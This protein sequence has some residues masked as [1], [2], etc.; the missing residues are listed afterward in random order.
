MRSRR[1]RRGEPLLTVPAP[2]PPYNASCPS[3]RDS[4]AVAIATAALS[5][6]GR[7]SVA[8]EWA[9]M[10]KAGRLAGD[11]G[12]R[13]A[14]RDQLRPGTPSGGGGRQQRGADAAGA[15]RPAAGRSGGGPRGRRGDAARLP[16]PAAGVDAGRSRRRG[17]RGT[18]AA[19]RAVAGC[20]AGTRGQGR[21]SAGGHHARLSAVLVG[22]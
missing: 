4:L 2:N 21:H 13:H 5:V 9:K 18:P 11:R 20:A 12:G 6:T 8:W 15:G 19:V 14:Y 17:R 7:L 10:T 22:P 1:G 3:C 16:G